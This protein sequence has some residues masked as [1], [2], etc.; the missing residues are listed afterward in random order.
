MVGLVDADKQASCK[1]RV[2]GSIT[3]AN[4][5]VYASILRCA[6]CFIIRVFLS[7]F[8][9]DLACASMRYIQY[10]LDELELQQK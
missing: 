2:T 1:A 4:C 7:Y 10:Q 8:R 9:H 3:N 6:P 5:Q